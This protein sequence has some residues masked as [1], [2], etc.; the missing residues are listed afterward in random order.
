MPTPR[1]EREQTDQ[2]LRLERERSDRAASERLA[3]IDETADA[4]INLARARA[5]ELLAAARA[6]TDQQQPGRPASPSS[7]SLAAARNLEDE[8]VREERAAADEALRKARAEQSLQITVERVETDQGLL[9][10]RAQA[11]VAL[12]ARDE[13]MGVV[14]HELRNMLHGI[15]GFASLIEESS[16]GRQDEETTLHAE[17]I[18]RSG[19]RM[20][21]LV[22]DLVDIASIEAGKLAVTPDLG[23]AAQVL[24][25]A[26]DTFQAQAAA[27]G[28]SLVL[29]VAAPL[30][31]VEFDAARLLQ[32]LA[33]VLANAVKFT[34]AAG[35]I[36]VRLQRIGD[37]LRFSLRDTGPGI[38]E[39]ELVAIFERFHQVTRHD[40]R[41]VG[42]GLYISKCIVHGHGGRIWAESE[43]GAGSTFCFTLPVRATA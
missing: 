28:I 10:E 39:G 12:A 31:Q 4:V 2:R 34:P 3:A 38:P 23:D 43:I 11:D 18:Q 29:E 14:S 41:G 15:I 9:S 13:F 37:E 16:R 40:R 26:V 30:P 36:E 7:S 21:R 42:L 6:K 24:R 22:G 27:R 1:S 25:E 5:D 19:A 32:V 35:R 8:T 20:D 33:N 17:R